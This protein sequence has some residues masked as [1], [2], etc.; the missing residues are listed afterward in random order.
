MRKKILSLAAGSVLLVI[1]LPGVAW[2]PKVLAPI[3]TDAPCA[4]TRGSGLFNGSAEIHSVAVDNGSLVGPG[5]I[6]GRCAADGDV[7]LGLVSEDLSFDLSVKKASCSGIKL[8]L[9]NV[10]ADGVSIDLASA[11]VTLVREDKRDRK[12]CA[13]AQEYRHGDLEGFAATLS[14]A[15]S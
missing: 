7:E 10:E 11:S 9:G 1:A 4:A 8:E 2:A 6:D 5:W 13:A 3:I 14:D 15:L 12:L